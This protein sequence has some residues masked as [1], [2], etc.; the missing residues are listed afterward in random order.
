MAFRDNIRLPVFAPPSPGGSGAFGANNPYQTN[1]R[2]S[3]GLQTARNASQ[4][5]ALGGNV[6]NRSMDP[7]AL[8][9]RRRQLFSRQA[10][11][12]SG[13]KFDSR[14][15]VNPGLQRRRPM[16][17]NPALNNNPAAGLSTD[18]LVRQQPA[19]QQTTTA[20]RQSLFTNRGRY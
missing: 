13:G 17:G 12:N 9:A 20:P 8:A 18:Q 15:G 2:A 10:S 5:R 16:F 1:D 11:G 4:G 14:P 19:L 7:R 3:F 6:A